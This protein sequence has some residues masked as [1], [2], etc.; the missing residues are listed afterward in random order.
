MTKHV[1]ELYVRMNVWS[2]GRDAGGLVY[3]QALTPVSKLMHVEKYVLE[4]GASEV[5]VLYPNRVSG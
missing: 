1:L 5:H 3:P 2:V 4:L